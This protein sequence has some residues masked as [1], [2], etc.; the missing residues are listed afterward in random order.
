MVIDTAQTTFDVTCAG[1]SPNCPFLER[2]AFAN[3]RYCNGLKLGEA[4]WDRWIGA[5]DYPPA[6]TPDWCPLRGNPVQIRVKG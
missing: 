3:Y 2:D 6:D 5:N 4:T 1:D